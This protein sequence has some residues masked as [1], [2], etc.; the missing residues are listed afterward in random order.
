MRAV[1]IWDLRL[2]DDDD[3][4]SCPQ[5]AGLRSLVL[6]AVFEFNYVKAPVAFLALVIGP[7]LLVGIAP[8]VL[9][10][11][12]R[13][14]YHAAA[15]VGTRLIVA[16]GLFAALV[17]A[18]LWIGRPLLKMAFDNSGH[19]HYSLVFPIFVALRE[20]LRSLAERFGGRSITPKQLDR[21]RRIFTVLAAL[22]FA[23]GGLA[24]AI[25]TRNS[26]H[27]AWI[28]LLHHQVVEYPVAS[29]SSLRDRIGL[30]LVNAPD[31]LAAIA[32]YASHV[33]VFHG[34]RHRDWIGT[35]GGV[36]LGSAPS[37]ALGSDDYQGSFHVHELALSAD[38]VIRLTST[39]RVKVRDAGLPAIPGAVDKAAHPDKPAA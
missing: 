29:I 33:L 1:R 23:G 11:Y 35:C 10:T 20:L 12:G 39:Q 26:P 13:L 4:R 3:N 14:A 5:G 2:G 38:G 17:G 21:R 27:R 7:A 16:L 19:L 30:A 18:A 15:L 6:S 24:L 25:T 22:L 9:V 36:V 31:I 28:I 32:P 8:S 37:V 34:H